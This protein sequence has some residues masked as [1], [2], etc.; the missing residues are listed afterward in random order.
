MSPLT[1]CVDVY[2]ALLLCCN[3]LLLLTLEFFE[4]VLLAFDLG[5]S[6]SV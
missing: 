5:G 4:H 3:G 1:K 6:T 2:C